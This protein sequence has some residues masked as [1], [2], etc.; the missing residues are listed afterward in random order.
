MHKDVLLFLNMKIDN[1][2]IHHFKI[3]WRDV[4]ILFLIILDQQISELLKI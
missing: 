1:K 4:K 3:L 2:L